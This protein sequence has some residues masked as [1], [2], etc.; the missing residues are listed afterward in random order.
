LNLVGKIDFW[1]PSSHDRPPLHPLPNISAILVQPHVSL[2]PEALVNDGSNDVVHTPQTHFDRCPIVY[3]PLPPPLLK[4]PS[5]H[6]TSITSHAHSTHP[7]KR[8]KY[9]AQEPKP[10]KGKHLSNYA[11]FDQ[12]ETSSRSV[13]SH[14]KHSMHEDIH[15]YFGHM[16]LEASSVKGKIPIKVD[17]QMPKVT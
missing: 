3:L 12:S 14:S 10:S 1:P 5:Q 9:L 2:P 16:H 11:K 8:L 15:I 4:K 7:L 13:T 6:I 17:S